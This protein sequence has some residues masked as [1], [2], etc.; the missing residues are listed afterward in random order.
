MPISTAGMRALLEDAQELEKSGLRDLA[1][2]VKNVLADDRHLRRSVA[3][4]V[5]LL[6]IAAD[7]LGDCLEV[8][9]VEVLRGDH[10]VRNA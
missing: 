1:I 9:G 2:R 8:G 5:L 3:V 4:D 7:L 10:T 6:H